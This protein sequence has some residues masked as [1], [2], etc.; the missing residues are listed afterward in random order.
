MHGCP[1]RCST[2]F[3]AAAVTL[4]SG[5]RTSIVSSYQNDAAIYGKL[6]NK[7]FHE[8]GDTPL[9]WWARSAPGPV[10]VWRTPRAPL[11]NLTQ[12]YARKYIQRGT[13]YNFTRGC[14]TIKHF[15]V[16]GETLSDRQ[17]RAMPSPGV[18]KGAPSFTIQNTIQTTSNVQGNYTTKTTNRFYK[19]IFTSKI[20]LEAN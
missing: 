16:L 17:S 5:Q 9:G 15:Y 13:T 7:L 11:N 3:W 1:H 10:I 14:A 4:A 12:S 19:T 2:N 18:V 20:S 8:L 6:Y